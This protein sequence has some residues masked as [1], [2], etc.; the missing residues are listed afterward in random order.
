MA[1]SSA[2]S[3]CRVFAT[4]GGL[5]FVGIVAVLSGRVAY[6]VDASP[7]TVTAAGVTLRSVNVDLPSSDRVFPGGAEAE[8]I[9]SNCVAC[10]SPAMVLNQPPLSQAAWQE[11]INK[12]RA[13]Y[14][15]PVSA[16]AVPAIVSYLGT[17]QSAGR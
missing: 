12:M 5:A 7:S 13:Q 16:E 3:T 1:A 9:N 6:A 11:E 15:A 2:V 14:K 10:H 17:I 8:A 4:A